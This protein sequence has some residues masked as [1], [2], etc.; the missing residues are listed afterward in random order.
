MPLPSHIISHFGGLHASPSVL[1]PYILLVT[2]MEHLFLLLM[3]Y[4]CMSMSSS[5]S[6]RLSPSR[7]GS[8]SSWE[9]QI[10]LSPGRGL[11]PLGHAQD[12]SLG[13]CPGGIVARYKNH[14]K[15]HGSNG[16]SS[17]VR[18]SI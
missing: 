9:A 12:T 4:Y 7:G 5:P 13:R 15:W 16:H 18:P 17:V 2:S 6:A 14:L 8:S 11:L 3:K 10:V 1:T